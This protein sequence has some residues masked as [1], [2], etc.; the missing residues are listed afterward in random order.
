MYNVHEAK[1]HFSKLL[2]KVS[3]GDHVVI[4]KAGKPV[5]KLVPFD[6]VEFS[7]RL[8]FLENET[9]IPDDFDSLGS[10][11]IETMFGFAQ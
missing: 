3:A 5:A 4:S 6:Y 9:V 8:G 2:A 11:E 1:T 7:G 10:T